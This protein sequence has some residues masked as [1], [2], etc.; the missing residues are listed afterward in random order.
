[1]W[2]FL[3]YISDGISYMNRN[4]LNIRFVEITLEEDSKDEKE[5][6]KN[7]KQMM[8][9]IVGLLRE[10]RVDIE[11]ELKNKKNIKLE[12][13]YAKLKA[14]N[15]KYIKLKTKI[16]KFEAEEYAENEANIAKLK[17]EFKKN[18][19]FQ[20]RCI[21]IAKKILNEQPIIKYHPSFLNGLEL[22]VIF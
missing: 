12:T 5:L 1:M 19:K 2:H 9:I 20:L 7:V 22:D 16:A 18:Q 17:N 11:N 14:K 10:K 13:E 3:F 8:E 6:C 4:S 21:Q 15:V